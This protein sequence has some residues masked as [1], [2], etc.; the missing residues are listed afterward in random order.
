MIQ[1]DRQGNGI[2]NDIPGTLLEQAGPN[3]VPGLLDAAAMIL[4]DG[5]GATVNA[6]K[7]NGVKRYSPYDER[8][9]PKTAWQRQNL[10]HTE[11]SPVN[12]LGQWGWDEFTKSPTSAKYLGWPLH[13]F[14]DMMVPHHLVATGSWGH[15][16]FENAMWWILRQEDGGFAET[17]E[18]I[19]VNG[20]YWWKRYCYNKDSVDVSAMLQEL[21]VENRGRVGQW[22]WNDDAS[23]YYRNGTTYEKDLAT[24]L[25][26]YLTPSETLEDV[27]KPLWIASN[28][29]ALSLM[30]CAADRVESPG[31]PEDA[32]CDEDE[33]FDS[34]IFSC[35]PGPSECEEPQV[36]I[37]VAPAEEEDEG[38]VIVI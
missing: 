14:G 6:R 17:E 4:A 8:K 30:V 20:Y 16:P 28:G 18:S 25:Y 35:E 11:F 13:A 2:Y 10:G 21:A 27:M 1:V 38:T 33:Y 23:R 7:S 19:L 5:A 37:D 15:S 22:A 26:Y 9:R 36:E 32:Q 29:A 24:Y 3:R 31:P 12:N 34:L